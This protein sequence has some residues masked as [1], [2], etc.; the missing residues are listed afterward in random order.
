MWDFAESTDEDVALLRQR[1]EALTDSVRQLI[2]ATLRTEVGDDVVA[3]AKAEIDAATAR[4][5]SHQRVDS[6]GISVTPDGDTV[7]WGNVAI[8]P[9]NPLAPPLEVVHDS[10]TRA[11]VD[12]HLGA[13]YEG[14]PGHLHGG[15][16]A[17][18]LDHLLG[19]VA[20]YGSVDTAVAT[21]TISFRYL[22]PTR[23]GPMRAEAEIQ[24]TVG[25][26]VF[27]TGHL[28]DGEGATVTAEGVFIVLKQ[29]PDDLPERA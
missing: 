16:G 12:T 28:A 9:R 11:H 3:S 24:E 13:A 14:P 15:Y 5:Q 25:R 17:L 4:L 27:V 8:G 6:L 26:K 19:H 29:S 10:P 1:Y 20:S 2:D 7:A 18:V 21:G 23:L 22:R